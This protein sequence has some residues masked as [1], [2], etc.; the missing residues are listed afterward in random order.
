MRLYTAFRVEE[1]RLHTNRTE[2]SFPT[3]SLETGR[4]GDNASSLPRASGFH[5]SVHS[6]TDRTAKQTNRGR[7]NKVGS[8]RH[9]LKGRTFYT[10]VPMKRADVSK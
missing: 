1:S 3:V 4:H 8:N 2:L 5:V 6:Q 9:G 10:P 7:Q